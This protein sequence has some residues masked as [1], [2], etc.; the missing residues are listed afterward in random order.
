MEREE[1]LVRNLCFDLIASLWREREH[2]KFVGRNDLHFELVSK[3][4]PMPPDMPETL[5][6]MMHGGIDLMLDAFAST[7]PDKQEFN[8]RLDEDADRLAALPAFWR[9]KVERDIIGYVR[10]EDLTIEE[11]HELVERL[12]REAAQAFAEAEA[13]KKFVPRGM[14]W[15]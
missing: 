12:D 5:T 2:L 4:D 1:E 14:K 3:L 7:G 10:A 13:L 9:Y 6:E 11:A 15:Q 8:N